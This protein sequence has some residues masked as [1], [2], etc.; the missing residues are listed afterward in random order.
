[1]TSFKLPDFKIPIEDR[2]AAEFWVNEWDWRFTATND[3]AFR[4][5]ALAM[6][7][8]IDLNFEDDDDE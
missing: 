5:Q 4:E 8:Y 2:S 3:Q 7:R 6:R 1:M